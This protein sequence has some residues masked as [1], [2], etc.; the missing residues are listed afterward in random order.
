MAESNY[1]RFRNN[2][3]NNIKHMEEV[4]WLIH[5]VDHQLLDHR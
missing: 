1:N 4:P 2:D 3:L 5:K